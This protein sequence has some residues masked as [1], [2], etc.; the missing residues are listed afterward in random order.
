[1]NRNFN[2]N[3]YRTEDIETLRKAFLEAETVIIG[4]GAGLSVSAG[5]TYSGERFERYFADFERKYGF[6][7]MYSGGFY[8]YPSKGEFWAFWSR[9]IYINRYTDTPRPVYDQLLDLVRD[10]DYFVITTN[11]D[12]CFQ[13]AGFDKKRLFYTQGDYGLFQCSRPCCQ[14]TYDNEETIR[15]MVLSQGFEIDEDRELIIPEGAEIRMTVPEE[16]FPV[17]PNCGE[18]MTTNLRIDDTFVQDEGWDR[19]AQRYSEFLRRHQNTKTLFLE[20]GVGQNTPA[21]IK[22]PFWKMTASWKDAV[23]ACL[24]Y[25]EAYTVNEIKDRSVCISGDI[26]E[27]IE[28]LK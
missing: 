5:Y 25:G 26:A 7:D 9:N 12:H 23:Y 6:R 24:N 27:I 2:R 18:E 8:P 13:K 17:C 10:K 16:L 15:K 22:Y 28:K 20:L 4:A 3:T 1:M 11:V 21:I 19:A 14:K